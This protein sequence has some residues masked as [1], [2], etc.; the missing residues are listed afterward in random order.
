[1]DT[2]INGAEPVLA[3]DDVLDD[4]I[5]WHGLGSRTVMVT[6]VGIDGA[7]PRPLG[8][9]MAVAEDGRRAGYLSG[10]CL[11][12]SVVLESLRVLEDG[13]RIVRYGKGSPYFDI[14][15]PCGSGLELYFQTV[16]RGFVDQSRELRKARSA[17]VQV[18]DLTTGGMLISR[19]GVVPRSRRYGN[20]FHRAHIPRLQVQLVG[21]GPALAA[22]A[23]MVSAFGAGVDVVT[24]DQDTRRD[25][26]SAGFQVRGMTEP[27]V[28]GLDCLDPYT[29]AVVTFHDHSW[30][31]PVL[32]EMLKSQCFY[33]GVLGRRQAHLDRLAKLSE[34]GIAT[35]QAAR[36]RTPAGLIP[37]ARSRGTLAVSILAEIVSEAKQAG[38]LA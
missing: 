31:A 3:D 34:M 2:A 36:V 13:P 26:L 7:T 8:A 4:V 9:Q 22:V 29:A 25:L 33:I 6:L 38:I 5:A 37:S 30:E 16:D 27:R 24:P 17:F 32:A 21:S 20:T 28:S 35:E 14:K 19:E 11:E 18:L 10:G 23:T 12:E 1:M 15:L